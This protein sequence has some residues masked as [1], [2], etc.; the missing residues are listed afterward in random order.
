MIMR[1]DLTGLRFGQLLVL[2]D[3]GERKQRA[4]MWSCQCD[5]GSTLNVKTQLLKRDITR[6]CGCLQR[7]LASTRRIVDHTGRKFGMLTALSMDSPGKGYGSAYAH[8]LCRCDCGGEKVVR[9]GALVS[10]ETISC[11][12]ARKD[13]GVQRDKRVRDQSVARASKRKSIGL[14]AEGAFTSEQITDLYLKQRG[15]CAN[16]GAK[17]GEQFHRDHKVA[18]SKG[19]SNDITN[20]ELL[21]GGC[22]TRKH[23][24]DP[25]RWANENGRLL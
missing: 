25:I 24:K 3:S 9:S 20:I 23:A 8:W 15:K 19:G 6:S 16:C 2:G 7:E 13:R 21:C 1:E 17:L 12:C 10:G 5:C 14:N 22:N 18:L 11:G 4:V